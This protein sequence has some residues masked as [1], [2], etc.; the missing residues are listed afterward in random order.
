MLYLLV[1][2]L[3]ESLPGNCLQP[4]G[5]SSVKV[6]PE[7]S[8]LCLMAAEVRLQTLASVIHSGRRL[9]RLLGNRTPQRTAEA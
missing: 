7:G 4:Q 1:G 5:T 8:S 2:M 9:R 6:I 3:A